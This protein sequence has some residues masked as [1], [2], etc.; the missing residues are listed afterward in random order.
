MSNKTQKSLDRLRK[1]SDAFSLGS[2][3]G[4]LGYSAQIN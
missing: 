2:A 4:V 1:I 3:I